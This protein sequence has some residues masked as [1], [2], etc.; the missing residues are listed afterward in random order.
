[1]Q[2]RS[3]NRIRP[4]TTSDIPEMQQVGVAAWRVAYAF[5]GPAYIERGLK[6]WWTPE[7]LATCLATTQ[8]VV[9]ERDGR[10]LGVGNLDTRGD[11][12]VIW[13]LYVHPAAQRTGLGRA[14][15]SHL[16]R[17]APPDTARVALEYVAGNEHAAQ[18]YAANG[19]TEDHRSRSADPD[20]P[21]TVWVSVAQDVIR[22]GRHD[23]HFV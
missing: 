16:I 8:L 17:I 21:E 1:M 11:V 9:A 7:A 18:F 19:F 22:S 20:E 6:T 4:A 3:T 15:L 2:P 23:D 10:I 14:L 13:K 5:A 12:P